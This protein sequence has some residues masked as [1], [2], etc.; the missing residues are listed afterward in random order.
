MKQKICVFI[1]L[2]FLPGIIYAITSE[3]DLYTLAESRYFAKNYTVALETYDDFVKTYPLSDLIPDVQYRR[4][5]CFYR[6]GRYEDSLALLKKIEERYRSTRFFDYLQFWAGLIFYHQK[7]YTQAVNSLDLFLKQ[8]DEPESHTTALFYKGLSEVFL[9]RYADGEKTL[10]ALVLDDT[11]QTY[12]SSAFVLL[13]FVYLQEEKHE[14]IVTRTESSDI[15]KFPE[16][17]RAKL[18]YYRAEALWALER[19]EAS[20][21]LYRQII[22]IPGETALFAFKRLFTFA[23]NNSDVGEMEDLLMKA[24]ERFSGAYDTLT[25]FWFS[26]GIENY[27]KNNLDLA[28]HF[29]T[30]I[31]DTRKKVRITQSVPLYLAEIYIKQENY[32]DA[33]DILLTYLRE[34]PSD[35]S[36][37]DGAAPM[38]AS[39][40]SAPLEIVFRLGDI[41]LLLD[42]Y[43][44]AVFYY[45]RCVSLASGG[46]TPGKVNEENP[47]AAILNTGEAQT[48]RMIQ[49]R[50]EAEYRLAYSLYRLGEV[51]QGLERTTE[52][53][54]HYSS[55]PYHRELLRLHVMLLKKNNQGDSAL[56]SLKQYLALYKD[57]TRAW[58]DLL[59]I[60]FAR[61]DYESIINE[62]RHIDTNISSLKNDDSYSY[63]LSR[64]LLGLSYIVKKEYAKAASALALVKSSEAQTAGLSLVMPYSLFYRGWALYRQGDFDDAAAIFSQII[65]NY[66]KHELHTKALYFAGWSFYSAGNYEKAIIYFSTLA[67]INPGETLKVKALF[68]QAKSLYNMDKLDEAKDLFKVIFN[69]MQ[70]SAFADDAL[71]EYAAILSRQEDITGAAEAYLSLAEVYPASTLREDALYRRGEVYFSGKMYEKARDAFYEYRLKFPDGLLVDAA[72]YWGGVSSYHLDEKFGAVLLWEKIINEYKE[73]AYRP[74]A[75]KKTADVYK[76]SG[77]YSKALSLYS[78]LIAAYDREASAV[79]AEESAEELRYLILGL[80]K[81]EAELTVQIERNKGS[82]TREGR[83]ALLALA[84]L[85]LYEEGRQKLD[86][87]YSILLDVAEKTEDLDTTSRARFLLGEYFSIVGDFVK[88]GNEFLKAALVNPKDKDFM[89]FA[90]YKAAEMMKFAHKYEEVRGLVD[91]L[92]KNFPQSHWAVEG[93]RLLEGM[94]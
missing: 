62:I 39:I 14:L 68:F 25:E 87:A 61:G 6:L 35:V 58:I 86:L 91:R 41:S 84:K 73:S 55:G 49:R 34:N 7:D 23:Q 26:L 4:A 44:E 10:E 24:E 70:K 53:L 40:E 11:D 65:R 28:A 9:M 33:R 60:Y 75:L 19:Q 74:N 80:G 67:G 94:E 16:K 18:M 69:K 8:V 46:K 17:D 29:F 1:I 52:V 83:E 71:F 63:I 20:A 90:I 76:E 51:G 50:M 37:G 48:D 12:T 89:A 31:W 45:T 72:L 42:D 38:D 56:S 5:V 57:D 15:E 27:K 93:R 43:K 81:K 79:N 21:V 77:E 3:K 66:P 59:R 30:K 78:E 47:E 13:M 32:I 54:A 36:S 2:F 85:Y 82:Q 88:A 22:E 64:Y 92:E